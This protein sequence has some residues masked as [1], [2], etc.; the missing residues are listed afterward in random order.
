MVICR[1]FSAEPTKL[2]HSLSF[3]SPMHATA[4][5]LGDLAFLFDFCPTKCI[6]LFNK[7]LNVFCIK[8]DSSVHSSTHVSAHLGPELFMK[9][10]I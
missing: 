8:K 2:P 9:F 5:F 4:C 1:I 10:P 7:Y 3:P 6:Y